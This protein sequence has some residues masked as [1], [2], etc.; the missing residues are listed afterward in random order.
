MHDLRR[1]RGAKCQQAAHKSHE[2]HGNVNKNVNAADVLRLAHLLEGHFKEVFASDVDLHVTRK[3]VRLAQ[4]PELTQFPAETT[5]ILNRH[6]VC[7]FRPEIKQSKCRLGHGQIFDFKV[8]CLPLGGS[9]A[10]V[11]ECGGA[12]VVVDEVAHTFRSVAH[13]PA[14]G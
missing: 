5:L 13:L 12:S 7:T 1:D 3:C 4:I 10:R 14:L 11:L 6:A 9:A 8:L 2:M